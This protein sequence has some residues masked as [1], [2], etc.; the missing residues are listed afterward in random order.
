M[1]GVEPLERFVPGW[2]TAKPLSALAALVIAVA[3]RLTLSAS[4][5]WRG[6]GLLMLAGT[7]LV[8][9]VGLFLPEALWIQRYRITA[10]PASA[11]LLI[12][13]AVAL[14]TAPG[15]RQAS[16]A[17]FLAAASAA[18]LFIALIGI[19][20]RLLLALPPLVDISLPSLLAFLLLT[21]AAAFARP[22]PAII[23]RLTSERP[24]AL[25]TRRLLPAALLLPL[26]IG[27]AELAA[28]SSGVLDSAFGS[29]LQTV[30]T[31]F[32]LGALV[33]W[34]AQRLDR[35]DARR[36]EAEQALRHAYAELDRRVEERTAAYERANAALQESL[37]VLRGM[38]ESTPDLIVVKDVQGRV[39]M[40]N[41][42]HRKAIG[43]P[44]S[45]IVGRTAGEFLS[46]PELAARIVDQ[47]QQVMSSGLVQRVEEVMPTPDGPRTYLA[48]KAPLTDVHGKVTGVIIVAKDITERKNTELE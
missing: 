14:G 47:D 13:A 36:D 41:P 23:E 42:A 16:A 10:Y 15:A 26:A 43:K 1:L 27:W 32:G 7:A 12:T 40:S 2:P 31:M 46:D 24:G 4:A 48:T 22:D 8:V 34:G 35:L 20:Y 9:L 6:I 38:A 5:R 21:Y 29:V 25:I 28:E 11:L 44:E 18:L 3:F 19:S 37:A 33:V 45:D 30:L 39:I 17:R